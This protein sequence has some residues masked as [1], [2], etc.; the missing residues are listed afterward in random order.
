MVFLED[1]GTHA[2]FWVTTIAGQYLI[3]S[4]FPLEISF[5]LRNRVIAR[6]LSNVTTTS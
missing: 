2:R 6:G 1:F 5:L 4:G 3:V